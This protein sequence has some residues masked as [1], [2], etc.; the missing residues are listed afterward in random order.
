VRHRHERERIS[1]RVRARRRRVRAWQ[2]RAGAKC[3]GTGGEGPHVRT[4]AR[5]WSSGR[6]TGGEQPVTGGPARATRPV[7]KWSPHP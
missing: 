7:Q 4:G 6:R 5:S 2:P 3:R 1:G